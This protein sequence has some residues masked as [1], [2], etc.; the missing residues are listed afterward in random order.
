MIDEYEKMDFVGDTTFLE[1]LKAFRIRCIDC[2]NAKMILSDTVVK[3]LVQ[4][5]LKLVLQAATDRA[6]IEALAKKYRAGIGI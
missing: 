3:K 4:D 6:A 1:R 5:E 2:F